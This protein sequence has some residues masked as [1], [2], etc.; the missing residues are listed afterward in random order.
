MITPI[1]F[2]GTSESYP[3]DNRTSPPAGSMLKFVTD[4]LDPRWYNPAVWVGYPAQYAG[5]M[6]Y[7]Q[8]ITTAVN[9][10]VAIMARELQAGNMIVLLGF[11]QGATICRRILAMYGNGAFG[12]VNWYIGKV[13]GAGLIA[14]PVRPAGKNLGPQVAPG[15]GVAGSE[16]IWDKAFLLE[17]ANP[18]D[19]ICCAPYNSLI[20]TFADFTGFFA[21]DGRSLE[22]WAAT[23]IKRVQEKGWQNANL[24]WGQFWQFG[25]RVNEAIT[26]LQGYLPRR[27]RKNPLPWLPDIVSNPG[28][29]QHTRYHIDFIP[30]TKMTGCELLAFELNAAGERRA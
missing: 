24:D 16:P 21:T 26:G 1:V 30:G 23:S 13:I 9:N 11:S 18:K 2:G 28:G 20:R 5:S 19:V 27:T 8:S 10:A 4:K 29:G 17:I 6:S 14:D 3:G 25:Q 12:D 22:Q 7:E 15:S